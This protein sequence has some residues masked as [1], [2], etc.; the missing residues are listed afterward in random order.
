ME[1]PDLDVFIQK[2]FIIKSVI[3][4]LLK[5]QLFNFRM[6]FISFV[7]GNVIFLFFKY[8]CS[9]STSYRAATINTG[10]RQL[11]GM[12]IRKPTRCSIEITGKSKQLRLKSL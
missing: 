9:V 2:K 7:G 10:K 6:F 5:K 12:T 4:K 8:G 3:L 1:L 11:L